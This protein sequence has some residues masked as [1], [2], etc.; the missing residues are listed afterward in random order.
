V[1]NLFG[2]ISVVLC[3]LLFA[4][5][6]CGWWMNIVAIMDCDFETPF[7]AETIRIVG[8]FVAPVG[9]V[10]GWVDLGK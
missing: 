7:K 8:I 5:A 4:T 9:C 1:E 3:V 6:V 10:A 2:V